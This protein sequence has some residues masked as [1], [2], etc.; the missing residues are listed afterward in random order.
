MILQLMQFARAASSKDAAI[1]LRK[2]TARHSYIAES[3]LVTD[4]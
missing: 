3:E 4:T 2:D 1:W